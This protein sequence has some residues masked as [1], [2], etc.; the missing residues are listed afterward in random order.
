MRTGGNGPCN[1]DLPWSAGTL[2]REPQE[3]LGV[4]R[5]SSC[6]RTNWDRV[7]LAPFHQV[8]A[9]V[10]VLGKA[11]SPSSVKQHLAAVQ[12]LF[13]WLVVGQ[14]MP[15][16]PAHSVRGPKP[17]VNKGKTPVLS[18]EEARELLDSIDAT[19]VVG[20]RDWAPIGT[21]LFT[22]ARVEATVSMDDYFPQ[23]KRW[24]IRLHE[25]GGKQHEMP[26]HHRLEFLDAYRAAAQLSNKK[27]PL[28]Q[29]AN[30]QDTHRES[31]L[32][33]GCLEDDPALAQGCWPKDGRRMS[34]LQS[35]RHHELPDQWWNARES[36]TNGSPFL[37]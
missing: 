24:S 4:V 19:H 6:L 31:N 25:N 1:C 20:L 3:L 15:L 34:Q 10:E 21:M 33:Q 36:T 26:D 28:F 2:A 35:Y 5:S 30:N 27:A 7:W 9:Y 8:A 18:A 13:D 17:I 29:S 22:C 32:P 23:G 14:V 37:G 16:N 12:M 11:H